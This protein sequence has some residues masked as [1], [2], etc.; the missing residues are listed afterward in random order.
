VSPRFGG[1]SAFPRI[2]VSL[3]IE[4]VINLL[5][6]L[7]VLASS[8]WVFRDARSLGITRRPGPGFLNMSPFS[9]F[10]SCLLLFAVAFPA[11]L[12]TRRR[13]KREASTTTPTSRIHQETDLISQL[14][15]LADLHSQGVVSDEEFQAKK[16]DLVREMLAQ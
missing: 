15:A 12:F 1:V 5:P 10:V 16:K 11:Y 13:Y 6:Y 8:L 3:G 9:W 14:S 2:D 7:V 4:P